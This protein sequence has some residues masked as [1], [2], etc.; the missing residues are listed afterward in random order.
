L[1]P[2]EP[3]VTG[4]VSFGLLISETSVDSPISDRKSFPVTE[5]WAVA[6]DPAKVNATNTTNSSDLR[7][8][9][10]VLVVG[11][12]SGTPRRKVLD[13]FDAAL[14]RNDRLSWSASKYDAFYSIGEI[15]AQLRSTR[16][17]RQFLS[18]R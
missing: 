4:I 7:I 1:A 13:P 14:E 15:R 11:D 10:L 2:P 9:I 18:E 5:I 6:V 12:L 8:S 16:R 3:R 17:R